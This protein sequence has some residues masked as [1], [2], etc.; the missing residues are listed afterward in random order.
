MNSLISEAS[1]GRAVRT[2]GWLHSGIGV[3]FL[4]Q[5]GMAAWLKAGPASGVREQVLETAV[6]FYSVFGGLLLASGV[7]LL[8]KSAWGVRTSNTACAV[9]LA[10]CLMAL[11]LA[12]HP[13]DTGS[14]AGYLALAAYSAL[15]LFILNRSR[16]RDG[17]QQ[18]SV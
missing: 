4:A 8:K 12:G 7:L 6:L 10:F 17:L 18:P 11:C 1:G 13:S 9:L 15:S 16:T 5:A 14:A 2:Y 3:L